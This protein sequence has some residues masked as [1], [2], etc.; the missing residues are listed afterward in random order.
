MLSPC[1]TAHPPLPP[2]IFFVPAKRFFPRGVQ[3]QGHDDEQARYLTSEGDHVSFRYEIQSKLGKGAFG[4]VYQALDHKTGER[5]AL[6]II[7]NE[8]RF[9][10]Q[11]KTEVQILEALR[12]HSERYQFVRM[13]ESFQFRGHLCLTFELH[14]HD[15]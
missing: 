6:K 9:H 11:G 8:R 13:I 12:T 15:L 1:T 3:N 7:R 2:Q 14:F 4:D 10:I 5:V